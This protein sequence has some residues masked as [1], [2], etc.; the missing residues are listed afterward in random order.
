MADVS[1]ASLADLLDIESV[2]WSIQRH[3]ELS[4]TGDGRI[5]AAELASPLWTAEVSLNPAYHNEAKQIAARIRALRGPMTAFMLY[6]PVSKYPQEDHDGSILGSAVVT[7]TAIGA[8]RDTLAFSGLPAGYK[9]TIGDKV[10]ITDASDATKTGLFEFSASGTANGAGAMAALAVFPNL[11]AWANTGDT[12]TLKKPAARVI[13]V[14]GS[15]N[16]G[17]ASGLMTMGQ[18]LQV[19]Q[20]K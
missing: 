3:D 10:Q 13:V 11:P 15:H 16:P 5:I 4:G 14:P 20:K 9:L 1:L 19:I 2:T 18:T 8:N 12:V 7:I 6:D 17:S